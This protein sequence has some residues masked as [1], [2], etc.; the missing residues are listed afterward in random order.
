MKA[1]ITAPFS[2]EGI[3]ILSKYMEVEIDGWGKD[4]IEMD[5]ARLLEKIKDVDV[6][7]SEMEAADKELID[8]GKNLKILASP[9][10][11]PINIDTNYAKSKNIPVFYA[12][13][14]NSNGVAELTICLMIAISR[15]VV[16][17]S[18][19]IHDGNWTKDGEMTYLKF[20][21]A[22]LLNKKL[23][24]I[25]LGAIG[26]KVC[27]VS[28]AIG[29]NVCVYDPYIT[30]EKIKALG[31]ESVSLETLF[32]ES[33]YVSIHCKV[34]EE[35]KGLVDKRLLGLMKSTAFI[36]N[37]ARSIIVNEKD[38]IEV[39]KEKR[40]KG[41]AL[42]VFD[43]EPIPKDHPFLKLDNCLVTPHIGG[44]THEIVDHH[45]RIIS[46]GIEL[47]LKGEKPRCLYKI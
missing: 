47:Y 1:L 35:T 30:D 38:L 40:I 16:E 2:N 8:A 27:K 11:N 15:M 46:E 44:A 4:K 45:S 25:G 31:V 32:K 22:E 18:N 5:R 20:R 29:M 43:E 14:R 13:G 19:F 9:R 26:E 3:D 17:S 41:A 7:I 34:T 39:L 42:D 24:L 21:G 12:P 10:G 28:K 6:F 33:D 23:G 36:I 37:T